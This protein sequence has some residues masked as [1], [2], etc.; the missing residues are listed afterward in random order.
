MILKNIM[1]GFVLIWA[2]VTCYTKAPDQKAHA[3]DEKK[4]VYP[5]D[6]LY[7]CAP[8]LDPSPHCG[9]CSLS[10]WAKK[11]ETLKE[12]PVEFSTLPSKKSYQNSILT[13]NEFIGTLNEGAKTIAR[14]AGS[15]KAWIGGKSLYSSNPELFTLNRPF[16]EPAADLKNFPFKPYTQRLILKPESEVIFFGDLHGSIH[17]FIRDLLKLQQEGYLDNSFKLKKINSYMVFLGDYIDRGIYGVEV[18]YTLVRLLIANPGHV[19]LTRGNHE[20]YILMPDF[21]KK[22]TTEEEKDN[23]PSFIDELYLKFDLSVKDEVTIFRF[24]ELLPQALYLGSGTATHTD[25]VQCCH[26]GLELGYDPGTLLKAESSVSFE[27]IETLWRKK[28]FSEKLA[29]P[30]QRT[31]KKE[32]DLSVLCNDIQDI[33]P[34][35]PFFALGDTGHKVYMGFMWND[36]YVDPAKKVGQRRK[37]FT[38]WVYGKDLTKELLSWGN[39]KRTTLR[40]VM[41][42][43]Q[44]N[45][46][47]GG[48]MLDLLCCSKGI[49]DV[50]GDKTVHNLVSAPN[51]KL[52]DTGEECF[53]YD[54]FVILSLAE[55]F[56][57]WQMK[58]YVQDNG[59]QKKRWKVKPVLHKE[60]VLQQRVLH[61]PKT[62]LKKPEIP[63]LRGAPVTT[64]V[65]PPSFP[66]R[67]KDSLDTVASV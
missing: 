26:G 19:I 41:R 14:I 44:H 15:D 65:T 17:S 7:P 20:D 47:T 4:V 13:L 56:K 32:F 66:E 10:Q 8:L 18:F 2:P 23:A 46:E 28:N 27:R 29:L 11:I 16:S 60:H 21:R 3:V 12:R 45:N 61:R 50:W 48:P 58:H 9:F 24:Y 31:I 53:T 36:F 63:A 51:S 37:N 64:P 55:K 34:L 62:G 6:K 35:A 38:G 33:V 52:E 67:R 30:F 57:N 54:S 39:S 25:F 42:G 59:M 49:V 5:A 40:G 1:I 22:H 43:H